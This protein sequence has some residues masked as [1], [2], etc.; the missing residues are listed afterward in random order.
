MA[1][2]QFPVIHQI[3]LLSGIQPFGVKGDW[4]PGLILGLPMHQH[5]FDMGPT[6]V[7]VQMDLGGKDGC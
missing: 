1:R 5:G 2:K 7:C 6:C 3:L 4:R